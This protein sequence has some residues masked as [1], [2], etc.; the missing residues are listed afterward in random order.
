[1]LLATIK[2]EL[3]NTMLMGMFVKFRGLPVVTRQ[4]ILVVSTNK[5]TQLSSNS[6]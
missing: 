1:M 2:G 4:A 3:Y 5:C 6:Q